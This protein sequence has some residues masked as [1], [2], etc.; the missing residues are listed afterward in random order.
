[1]LD[2]ELVLEWYG[3]AQKEVSV[4]IST[5]RDVFGFSGEIREEILRTLQ[6]RIK[7][8]ACPLC[9]TNTWT[10]ADGFVALPV[11]EGFSAFEVGGPALPCVALVCNNCG[12]TYLI[13]VLNIGLRHLVERQQLSAK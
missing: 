13:N 3:I 1:M 7:I 6:E 4:G 11:Q 12:N 8:Q 2:D 9:G 10:L 5:S